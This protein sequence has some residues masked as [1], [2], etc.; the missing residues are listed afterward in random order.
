MTGR[1][2]LPRPSPD[3]AKNAC[4]AAARRQKT[5]IQS[6]KSPFSY[7]LPVNLTAWHRGC[8]I[9]SRF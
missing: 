8:F 6:K 1:K 9:Y 4:F 7:L 5:I 3:A 2:H